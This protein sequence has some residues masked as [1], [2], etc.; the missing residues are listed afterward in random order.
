MISFDWVS[1][2]FGAVSSIAVIAVLLFAVA[3]RVN[4]RSKK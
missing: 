4:I 3:V 1:F 2:V